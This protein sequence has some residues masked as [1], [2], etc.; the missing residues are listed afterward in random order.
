MTTTKDISLNSPLRS[1]SKR[2]TKTIEA[3]ESSGVASIFDLMW[4]LPLRV[5]KV[6]PIQPISTARDNTYF[7]GSGKIASFQSRPNFRAKGKNRVPLSNLTIIVCDENNQG[8][9]QLKWFN[10]YPSV[11][12]KLQSLDSISF[13]GVVQSFQGNLQI[14]SPETTDI[15]SLDEKNFIIQYPTI[16]GVSSTHLK[17]LVDKIPD[18]LWHSADV[19]IPTPSDLPGLM[20]ALRVLHAKVAPEQ[21]HDNVKSQA[22]KALAYYEFFF[23]QIKHRVRKKKL[24]QSTAISISNQNC[25]SDLKLFSSYFPYQL[26]TD[27]LSTLKTIFSDIEGPGPM[28]RMVQGDVGCGK[29]TVALCAGL[30]V[31]QAGHQ[32]ALMAPTESLAQ[33]HFKNLLEFSKLAKFKPAL[34][35]GGFT[36]SQKSTVLS[37]L[38][39]G[40]IDFVIGTHSLFQDSVDFKSLG[41]AIIDEQH[42]F[43][44]N[45]RIRLV[46]KTE[47]AH[48]LL[49]SATPIP[50]SLSLTQYGDLEIS[51]I[52]TL[53]GHRKGFK[54]KIITPETYTKFLSFLKTRL[55]MDE[56]AYIVVPAIEE[57]EG[58]D[59]ANLNETLLRFKQYFPDQEV[60][61]L[62]GQLKSEAKQSILNDFTKGNINLLV[63]TSVV[64]V[65][66]DVENAT[67]M[68]ILNPERFGLSSLH[69]LRGRVGR[70]SKPGFCFLVCDKIPSIDSLERLRVIESTGDGFKIAEEDL[71]IRGEGDLFGTS[72]SGSGGFRRVANIVSDYELLELARANVEE[73]SLKPDFLNLSYVVAMAQNDHVVYTV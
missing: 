21:W 65:G 69:Q 4:L 6:P 44:V 8:N 24:N 70:G 38:K 32:V 22:R 66:I 68:A 49:M 41:L 16:N 48:C 61:G 30:K 2:V 10:C 50:R 54:T 34:L 47:G 40:S 36:S 14:V 1:L 39:D 11:V 71:R 59:I 35:L 55:S 73:L 17:K 64:E 19:A 43:G 45:Q 56:Q 52:K 7:R 46:G 62:H 18:S 72:Q 29:T 67:V 23:E 25:D 51:I 42:K 13:A 31:I 12:H 26:T 33:Q 28:M 5:H 53:P 20:E 27:Q 60:A 58:M 37:G 9:I 15:E 3:L 57:S 63:S